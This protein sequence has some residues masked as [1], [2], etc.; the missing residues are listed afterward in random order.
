MPVTFWSEHRVGWSGLQLL[1]VTWYR[2][3]ILRGRDHYIDD[4]GEMRI[5]RRQ[6]SGP[7]IDQGENLFVWAELVLIPSVLA[8]RPGVRWVP[9]DESSARLVVPFGAGEDEV[10]FRFDP[11]TGLLSDGTAMRYKDVGGPK[12][13]W[14]IGY[15]AWRRFDGG[16]YP[17]RITVTSS[18]M[19]STSSSLC[20]M[21]TIVLP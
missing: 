15:Q 11:A 8:T 19:A 20:V 2:I 18:E 21:I 16:L 14:R 7:E 6:I 3:P 12:V 10:V 9:I 4:R 1:T 17:S 13:G 5:G